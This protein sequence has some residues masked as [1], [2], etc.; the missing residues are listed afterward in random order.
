MATDYNLGRSVPVNAG[1][2]NPLTSYVY[3]DLISYNG[4]SYLVLKD[5]TGVT[6]T[7]DHVNY[8][9]V[10]AK[11]DTGDQ[12]I[13]GVQGDQG[14]QGVQ[15]IQGEKGDTGEGGFIRGTYATAAALAAAHPTGNEYN[16]AV[17]EDQNWYY[18]NGSAWAVGGSLNNNT[19]LN[20]INA[21][22]AA[23]TTLFNTTKALA[24]AM[25]G[26]SPKG[27]RSNLS[28]L[29]SE[30]PTGATGAWVI[31]DNGH[32]AFYDTVN[33]EWV[34]S[35]I[36]YQAALSTYSNLLE[37]SSVA[38]SIETTTIGQNVHIK[39]DGGFQLYSGYA[40]TFQVIAAVEGHKYY[41]RFVNSQDSV[42][43]LLNKFYLIYAD[44][45]NSQV[46]T[47]TIPTNGI[48]SGIITATKTSNANITVRTSSTVGL[49]TRVNQMLVDL[50]A[51]FG[52]GNEPTQA[53]FEDILSCFPDSWFSNANSLENLQKALLEAFLRYNNNNSD[54]TT[55]VGKQLVK[56]Y[57]VKHRAL[58]CAI[59]MPD[60]SEASLHMLNSHG[61]GVEMTNL[62]Q[63]SKH[64]KE[65]VNEFDLLVFSREACT[66]SYLS[67]ATPA[68][69]LLALT[70]WVEQ[71]K[72]LIYFT[73]STTHAIQ[74]YGA[75]GTVA[76]TESLSTILPVTIYSRA[77]TS[78]GSFVHHASY[79]FGS[80]EIALTG[81]GPNGTIKGFSV[82]TGAIV[83][84]QAVEEGVT[85]TNTIICK[86]GEYACIGYG[87]ATG[88]ITTGSYYR[89]ADVGI[90][91][92]Y[93]VGDETNLE[94]AFDCHSNRRIAAMGIDADLTSE[95]QANQLVLES[96]EKTPVEIGLVASKLT[97]DI[98]SWYRKRTG[99]A[100]YM[101]HSYA[102][103]PWQTATDELHV[104]PS[105][106]VVILNKPYRT[107][108]TNIS[109]VK[110][111]DDSV[112][113]SYKGLLN[114]NPSNIQY[115]Y[116][117]SIGA[118]IFHSDNIGATIK[119][120]YQYANEPQEWL[121]SLEEMSKYKLNTNNGIYL[122]GGELSV[123]AHTLAYALRENI[124]ICDHDISAMQRSYK[125][126]RG[127]LI[128]KFVPLFCVTMQAGYGQPGYDASI[129][130]V[131][132]ADAESTALPALMT[133]C[134]ALNKPY[135]WYSHDF[136]F[137]ETDS[138]GLHSG[139]WH[140]DWAK[141][142][143]SL[144]CANAKEFLQALIAVMDAENVYW[145]YR[146][147]YSRRY[148]HLSS[149]VEYNI[150]PR[151]GYSEIYVKN[152]G[153]SVLHGL[154]F[155]EAR[156]STPSEVYAMPDFDLPFAFADGELLLTIDL[157]PGESAVIVVKD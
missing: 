74:K 78:A 51:V 2:Y 155:R 15:G 1:T 128:P 89:Y 157:A 100:E 52:V 11:G 111:Q 108:Y 23:S 81:Y 70:Y 77:F 145:M 16:Y 123:D 93:L 43:K 109:S 69:I 3:F 87:G 60:Y 5:V 131:A 121:G 105:T 85:T 140:A 12:G 82:P 116:D 47:D 58:L 95:T 130:G 37:N 141:A 139:G 101:S 30:F 151:T 41:A 83:A 13:Q 80:K 104:V 122:T 76:L 134:K 127:G 124:I 84:L 126:I 45:T 31:S 103:F 114:S 29:E 150:V 25:A 107:D 92:K 88:G 132:R 73:S 129:W 22:L 4:G 153:S 18:W 38:A 115:G 112:T 94:M 40:S 35:G 59:N 62:V 143:Y 56:K 136:V 24:E 53:E 10:A 71:G 6:P 66:I 75:D 79:P 86:P 117:S 34:D 39:P 63:F 137:S 90:I 28:A 125:L 110:K 135:V 19:T 96:F 54:Y 149:G 27:I 138:R 133:R 8:F 9:Q 7:N 50:T 42:G 102:H 61:F 46:G 119:V 48:S 99:Q 118:L 91:A 65:W 113:F 68:E 20:N 67:P 36:T 21:Q 154:T 97:D 55:D 98:A 106:Q 64:Y 148:N 14:I 33:S 72:R 152:T 147:D 17:T 49:V 44:G 57:T 26:G 146:T 142:T 120:T 32:L 156:T 144:T